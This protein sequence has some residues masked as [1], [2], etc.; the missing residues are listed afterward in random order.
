MSVSSISSSRPRLGLTVLA[1]GTALLS[2]NMMMVSVALPEF[3][4]S[5]GATASQ[6]QWIMSAY[7]LTFLAALLPVGAL[8]DRAGRRRTLLAGM[9]LFAVGAGL[10]A[11]SPNAGFLIGSRALMGVAGSVFTPMSLA[12]IPS[13]FPPER[14]STAVAVWTLSGGI[15]AP[16]GPLVGGTMLGAFGWRSMFILDLVVAVIAAALC[17]MAIPRDRA[18]ATESLTGFPLG[19]SL[20][21]AAGFALLTWSLISAGGDH[22]GPLTWAVL[23]GGAAAVAAF[24]VSD[25][26]ARHRLTDL[27]LL[28]QPGFG[29]PALSLTLANLVM[30]AIMYAVPNY[31]E[32]IGGT[33]ATGTGVRLLPM[34]LTSAIA[35]M[36]VPRLERTTARTWLVPASLAMVCIGCLATS[37]VTSSSGFTPLG[38]GLSIGGLGVGVL[39]TYGMSSAAAQVPE[40]ERGAGAA[41]LNTLRQLGSLLGTA[42]IGS[43][44]L[45][46][47]Q[48][49]LASTVAG[50]A[51][52][53][54]ARPSVVAAWTTATELEGSAAPAMRQAV[55]DAYTSGMRAGFVACAVLAAVLAVWCAVQSRRRVHDVG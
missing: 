41:L 25:L 1:L 47:Y 13:L 4:R 8:G 6:T 14:Q 33:T 15:G 7:T 3:S 18:P 24:V 54:A 34:I 42:L 26:R 16:I 2:M 46:V 21:V 37:G 23:V 51:L 5:L 20:L 55:A 40:E 48:S 17:L 29:V 43:L 30:F 53:Q 38:I 22:R 39:Q 45:G 19:R 11:C 49:R 36:L 10:A 9:V 31:L 35:G 44:V 52:V 12:I 50:P 27:R 28:A 32:T